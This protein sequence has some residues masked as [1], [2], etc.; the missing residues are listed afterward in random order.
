MTGK[1]Q[2]ISFGYLEKGRVLPKENI[3]TLYEKA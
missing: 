2:K 1:I 3:T